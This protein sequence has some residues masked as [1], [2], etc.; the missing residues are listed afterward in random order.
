MATTT[1][2]RI[3][4]VSVTVG[5]QELTFESGKLAKQAD[6]SVLVRAG[7]T[8]VLAG[9]VGLR[10]W[11]LGGLLRA[12]GVGIFEVENALAHV[13]PGTRSV[14]ACV[15]LFRYLGRIVFPLHL[16]ADESA[17]SI[18]GE[19]QLTIIGQ[20]PELISKERKPACAVMLSEGAGAGP[21]PR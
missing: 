1:E 6:G 4:T 3:A 13:G 11:V 18:E 16:S 8:M 10:S 5:D 12:P 7:D 17:W 21:I 19:P 9:T 14:N 15:I 20:L 2:P